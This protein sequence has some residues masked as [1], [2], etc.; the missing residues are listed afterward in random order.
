MLNASKKNMPPISPGSI[1][2]LINILIKVRIINKEIKMIGNAFELHINFS[3]VYLK[4]TCPY[5]NS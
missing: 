1:L 5:K 2:L 3:T 4:V